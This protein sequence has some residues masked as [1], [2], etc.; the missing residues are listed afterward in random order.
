MPAAQMQ[1]VRPVAP[2]VRYI[3]TR[4]LRY[5]PCVVDL[6][7]RRVVHSCDG[8]PYRSV[9]GPVLP[10]RAG[11]VLRCG[12]VHYGIC[13]GVLKP[14]TA[15]DTTL[16]AVVNLG[17]RPVQVRAGSPPPPPLPAKRRINIPIIVQK[18]PQPQVTDSLCH[19]VAYLG[20]LVTGFNSV[21]FSQR[22]RG[23]LTSLNFSLSQIVIRKYN[24]SVSGLKFTKFLL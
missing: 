14:G 6:R 24:V 22:R 9:A 15:G 10:G 16:S 7:H 23:Q 20:I 18:Q 2:P 1:T 11:P 5:H 3:H 8:C 21:A 19:L 13:S 12:A 17:G 4:L